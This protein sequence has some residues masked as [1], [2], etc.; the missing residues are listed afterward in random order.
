[1]TLEHLED[2]FYR[3]GLANYTEADFAAI[4]LDATFYDNLKEISADETTHV[5]FLTAGLT[6]AGATP[7]AQCTYDFGVSTPA[8]FV[9]LAS[10]LEG[11]FVLPFSFPQS[12]IHQVSVFPRISAQPQTS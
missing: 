6:A 7:V 9:A 8:Q 5:A 1:M 11:K 12:L 3:E 2:T 4:G 10:V